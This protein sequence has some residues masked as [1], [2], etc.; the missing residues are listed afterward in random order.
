MKTTTIVPLIAA[1]FALTNAA[2][3]SPPQ[4]IARDVSSSI[5]MRAGETIEAGADWK[6]K[7]EVEAGSDWKREVEAGADWKVK[8]EI[9]AEPTGRQRERLR[10][11]P[12][13]K[14]C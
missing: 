8:R 11:E 4:S 6:A 9:E 12:I 10:Q 7:R 1:F 13:G 5:E 3:L 14:H 2:P